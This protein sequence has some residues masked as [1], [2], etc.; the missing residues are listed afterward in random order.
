[1]KHLVLVAIALLNLTPRLTGQSYFHVESME[2][3]FASD[4]ARPDSVKYFK[5]VM[6]GKP[7]GIC[8]TYDLPLKLNYYANLDTVRAIENLLSM[9][10]DTRLC[11]LEIAKYNP[12]SSYYWDKPVKDYSIQLEALFMINQICIPEAFSYSPI[13]ALLDTVTRQ[14][15]TDD[16]EIIKRAYGS[17]R[18]WLELI[19]KSSL[20]HVL[21]RNIM[22]LD[23]SGLKWFR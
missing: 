5:I 14:T 20:Q 16:G 3:G 11:V 8:R 15:G 4:T 6:N 18:N 10:G 9:E 19:K 7:R 22:P 23:N 2:R 13:P 17:Y 1:M 12:R 21:S